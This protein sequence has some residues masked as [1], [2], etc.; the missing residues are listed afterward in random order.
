[1]QEHL[2]AG[3]C[4]LHLGQ[5]E[6]EGG[7]EQAP[8]SHNK[9]VPEETPAAGPPFLL[10]PSFHSFQWAPSTGQTPTL[11]AL[12]NWWGQCNSRFH[13]LFPSLSGKYQL[14]KAARKAT[15]M[16]GAALNREP[17]W[18]AQS[19]KRG[20][21]TIRPMCPQAN[22]CSAHPHG[23]E[24]GWWD[25]L[26]LHAATSRMWRNAPGGAAPKQ[27]SWGRLLPQQIL[28]SCS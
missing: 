18:G 21:L 8:Q 2:T 24:D 11:P 16:Q 6:D 4:A 7:W 22:R 12:P 10:L 15:Q 3:L 28:L 19:G 9:G 20:C 1:M 23:S 17:P 25:S 27:G 13:P 5:G 26:Q 14:N